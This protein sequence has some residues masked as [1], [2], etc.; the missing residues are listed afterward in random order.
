[1][2]NELHHADCNNYVASVADRVLVPSLNKIDYTQ[3]ARNTTNMCNTKA[4]PVI[5]NVV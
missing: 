1:M 2:Y 4:V 5:L 3:Y